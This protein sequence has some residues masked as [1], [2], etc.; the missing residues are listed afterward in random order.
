MATEASFL[1]KIDEGSHSQAFCINSV[2]SQTSTV[3]VSQKVH[4]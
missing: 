4:K 3:Y 1:C 2:S